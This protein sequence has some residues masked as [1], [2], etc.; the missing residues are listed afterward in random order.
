MAF[1]DVDL[2]KYGSETVDTAFTPLLEPNL[3]AAKNFQDGLTFTSKY[4]VNEAG[5][6]A[7]RKLGNPASANTVDSLEFTHTSTADALIDINFDVNIRRSEKVFELVD[8]ARVSGKGAAKMD[9][10][11]ESAGEEF[12]ETAIQK[13]AEQATASATTTVVDASTYTAKQAIIDVRKE[14][15][16]NKA[17]ADVIM[18][19]V[20][21]YGFLLSFSGKEYTPNSNDEVLR[22][23]ALGMIYGAR[24]Y[25]N[26]F[27]G[28]LED[29][30]GT[31]VD[32]DIDFI[33]YD[34]DAY[35]IL[36]RLIGLRLMPAI[37]FVGSY[38]QY[39]SIHAFKVSNADRVYKKLSVVAAG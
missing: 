32:E 24:V 39:H 38:A 19:S 28:D 17:K 27:L 26:E 22:T 8:Q 31:G 35:S 37:D 7:I 36:S 30:G 15:R 6:I 1:I 16:S 29:T 13:L 33:M 23:G 4:E 25:E 20:D 3:W 14:L 18:A 12:Q 5:Q 21:F 2:V 9:I 34:H 10:V 11:L